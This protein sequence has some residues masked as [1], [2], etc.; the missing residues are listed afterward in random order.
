MGFRSPQALGG[1]PVRIHVYVENVDAFCS[2]AAAAGAEILRPVADQFYGDRSCQLL[3]PLP[4]T[5]GLSRLTWK[6]SVPRKCSGGPRDSTADLRYLLALA[7]GSAVSRG[8]GF[9]PSSLCRTASIGCDSSMRGPAQR[10]RLSRARAY[11]A[12]SSAPGSWRTSASHHRIRNV[13]CDARRRRAGRTIGTELGATGI[14][15]PAAVALDHEIDRAN[16]A[17]TAHE[18]GIGAE[19]DYFRHLVE[20]TLTAAP[21][22]AFEINQKNRRGRMTRR[23]LRARSACPILG[24]CSEH[25]SFLPCLRS[26]PQGTP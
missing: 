13:R 9:R 10:T 8:A 15:M 3:D 22:T 23:T 18:A 19:F 7:F 5:P 6:T 24:P 11:G 26:Q 2:R 17:R 20:C 12:C 25:A 14:V 21:N 16:F 4:A 1:S